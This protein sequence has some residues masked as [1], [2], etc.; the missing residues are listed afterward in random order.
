MPND[1]NTAVV[2]SV[3]SHRL[4]VLR[5]EG[6]TVRRLL[7]VYD[8]AL[9][10]VLAEL[11]AA[12]KALARGQEVD[13]RRRRRLELLARDLRA[14]VR[15]LADAAAKTLDERARE[16]GEAER[17]FAGRLG[18]TVG[19]SWRDVPTAAVHA[20]VTSP[21]GGSLWRAQLATDLVAVESALQSAVGV[22]LARGLGMD[23][24]AQIV[25]Q[26]GVAQTYRGRLVAIAR[27][28]IQR[29]ANAVALDSYARNADVI[30]G[31]QVLATLDS[32]TCAICGAQHD[33]VYPLV[34]GR[35]EGLSRPPPFHPR[36]RCFTAPVIK[37]WSDLG[38]G[39]TAANRRAYTGAPAEAPSFEAWLRG[40]PDSEADEVFG[41]TRAAAWRAGRLALADMVRGLTLLDLGEL[42]DRYPSAV[43]TRAA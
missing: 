3:T 37:S 4:A 11:D 8:R 20:A 29:V 36:C 22:A 30:S 41:P 2:D 10:D 40:R 16:V 1:V 32:R 24:A 33:R 25:R 15:L 26:A 19:V 31:V 28:E 42:A 34:G 17:R 5:Y 12:R 35:P 14:E 13:D 39:N 7:D 21:I 18:R 43:S 9:R 27:T 38:L 6:G 23:R